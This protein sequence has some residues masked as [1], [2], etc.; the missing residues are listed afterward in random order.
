MNILWRRGC[1][2][3]LQVSHKIY[4]ECAD[5]LYSTNTFEIDIK[6]DSIKFRYSWLTHSGLKP[7][8][9]Y[10]FPSDRFQHSVQRIRHFVINVEHVDSYQGMIKY[11]CGGPGLTAG[12]KGQVRDF[13][14]QIGMSKNLGRV[15]IRLSNGNKVLSD[16][17]RVKVHCIER[18]KNT[19]VTQSVLDPFRDLKDVRWAKVGGSVTPEYATEIE[20]AMTA[21]YT[22]ASHM[23]LDAKAEEMGPDP[24]VLW[25]WKHCWNA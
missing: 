18:E 3:I 23:T 25:R 10:A 12:V 13:V 19:E 5:M 11:N 14:Q 21:H 4:E 15:V 24:A 22:T 9:L 17:R 20:Q 16:I 8:I 2:S 6:Y 1:I 7:K